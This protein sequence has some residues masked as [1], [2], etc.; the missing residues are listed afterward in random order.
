MRTARTSPSPTCCGCGPSGRISAP[1]PPSRRHF[2]SHPPP[3]PDAPLLHSYRIPTAFPSASLPSPCSPVH[4]APISR[5]S[6]RSQIEINGA[7]PPSFTPMQTLPSRGSHDAEFVRLPARR[8]GSDSEAGSDSGAGS[9]PSTDPGGESCGGAN[10]AGETLLLL[11][12][13]RGAHGQEVPSALYRQHGERFELAQAC[14]TS[15][16]PPSPAP[17]PPTSGNHRLP[18]SPCLLFCLCHVT[19]VVSLTNGN[20]S[21][22]V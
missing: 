3:L 17:L 19:R 21:A 5:R 4:L 15:A 9:D 1:L 20:E 6:R 18:C 8:A 13:A 16:P 10:R 12:N 2:P 22:I 14:A 11:A 7:A